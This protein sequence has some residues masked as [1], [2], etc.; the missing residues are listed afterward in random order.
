M[1]RILAM[2]HGIPP[3]PLHL[4]AA[5]PKVTPEGGEYSAKA[6]GGMLRGGCSRRDGSGEIRPPCIRAEVP[7]LGQRWFQTMKYNV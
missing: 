4:H 3:L 2:E 5:P 1:S 6:M 7:M